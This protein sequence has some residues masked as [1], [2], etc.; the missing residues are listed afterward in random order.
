[1]IRLADI[2][3]HAGTG[4]LGDEDQTQGRGV[5]RFTEETSL[6]E[7]AMHRSDITVKLVSYI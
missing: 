1:M 7:I 3:T 6:Q 4:R 5:R 2:T